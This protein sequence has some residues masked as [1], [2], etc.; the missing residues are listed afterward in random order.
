MGKREF[1][2]N[3]RPGNCQSGYKQD[4]HESGVVKR[5]CFLVL[6]YIERNNKIYFKTHSKR[7]RPQSDLH[8]YWVDL[9]KMS[10]KREI[11]WMRCSMCDDVC[12]DTCVW[13]KVC[14]YVLLHVWQWS[15]HRWLMTSAAVVAAEAAGREAAE[16]VLATLLTLQLLRLFV[17]LLS[18]FLLKVI[19][20]RRRR[21]YREKKKIWNST[22]KIE[23]EDISTSNTCVVCWSFS[24]FSPL[25][26]AFSVG[27]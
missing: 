27:E 17:E 13:G 6:R 25:S 12:D 21:E 18:V 20:K 22:K 26:T 15:Y 24:S 9:R 16:V 3:K 2:Q 11:L 4:S 8:K 23:K 19:R 1:I 10:A 7:E 14:L 5:A